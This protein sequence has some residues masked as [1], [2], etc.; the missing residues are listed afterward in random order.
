M[1]I[2]SVLCVG[3]FI[4]ISKGDY[5]KMY[6]N[7]GKNFVSEINIEPGDMVLV[8]DTNIFEQGDIVAM[9]LNDEI[10]IRKLQSYEGEQPV[11]EDN[12]IEGC[13]GCV[14]LGKVVQVVY[15]P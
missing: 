10:A 15:S 13:N 6:I 1:L 5:Q 14:F 11:Y 8:S 4:K 2:N 7:V 12:N 9:R 3:F